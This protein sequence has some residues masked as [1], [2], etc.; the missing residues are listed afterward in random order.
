[1]SGL[2]PGISL[3]DASATVGGVTYTLAVTTTLAGDPVLTIPQSVLAGL[4][5]GQTLS[6]ALRFRDQLEDP[7]NY[8]PL[9]FSDPMGG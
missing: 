8:T 5:Q 4:A 7:I 6:V 2:S 3:A 1:M 9:L